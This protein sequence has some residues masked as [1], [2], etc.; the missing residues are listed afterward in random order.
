MGI[1]KC[2]ALE[3]EDGASP[4]IK[5]TLEREYNHHR[6][7][8]NE[9]CVGNGQLWTGMWTQVGIDFCHLRALKNREQSRPMKPS[10]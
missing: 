6:T 4:R 7:R 1:I 2:W 5:S 3:R 8:I 10:K 9:I